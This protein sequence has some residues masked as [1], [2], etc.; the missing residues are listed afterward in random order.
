MELD[1]IHRDVVA[2]MSDIYDSATVTEWIDTFIKP[3]N[4]KLNKL[5]E[6]K[7]KLLSKDDWPRRPFT[8]QFDQKP[9]T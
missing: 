3:L 2:A 9:S 7:E 5:W 1:Y 4:I 6:A 8:S